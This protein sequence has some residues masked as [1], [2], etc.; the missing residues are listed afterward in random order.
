[1]LQVAGRDVSKAQTQTSRLNRYSH[2]MHD[3]AVQSAVLKRL[4]HYDDVIWDKHITLPDQYEKP[5][6]LMHSP[7]NY[8]VAFEYERW[9]KEKKAHL[10]F[11]YES[12][13][14]RSSRDTTAACTICSTANTT[15]CT[16]RPSSRPR[17]GPN[18]S[19]IARPAKSRRPAPT[20][21]LMPSRTYATVFSSFT[22]PTPT[23]GIPFKKRGGV[24]SVSCARGRPGCFQ[25]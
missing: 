3:L 16:T 4:D 22:S 14:G 12:R 19:T 18:T 2:I 24:M 20:S 6:A 13:E 17:N 1:M 5:D 11:L 25:A 23:Q 21:S 15:S 9:R 8:W 10:S 7:K